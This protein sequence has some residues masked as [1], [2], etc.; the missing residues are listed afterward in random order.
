[1]RRRSTGQRFAV[2]LIC[3]L[4]LCAL[5]P[6]PARTAAELVVRL[7]GMDLPLSIS[8]LG[9]WIRGQGS[10]SSELSV[11]LNLLEEESRQGVIDLLKA[12]L[13]N[14]R[15]MARQI[16]NSWAGR[17]LLDQVSDL[18]LV[19][20]DTTGQTVQM[21]LESL[22]AK[23]PEVS[24]FD[25]LEALPAQR[26]R[27]DLDALLPVAS[28]WRLQLQRQQA[29]VKT[30][31]QLPV[32]S[33]TQSI[34]PED[35]DKVASDS[36]LQQLTLPVEHRDQPL[37]LQLWRPSPSDGRQRSH[38]LVLMPGLGGSPDHFRWLGRALSHQGWPVLVLEHPGSDALAVQALLEGRQPPPGAEVLPDRLRDLSAV[39]A[40]R[41]REVFELPGTRLVLGGHSLGA[42]T[43]LLASGAR[44]EK[45][46]A[47]R[48]GQDL[49]DLPISN[50]SR[51]LQCQ[52]EDVILPEVSPPQELA[53]VVGLNSFGSLL[54]PRQIPLSADVAVFLSGGTLDLITPPLSEQLGLLRSL[55][56][57]PAT[58][59]VLVEG[60]SHFSPVRVE[61]Q[62][63]GGQGEDVFQ[64]G[65]ELVGVQPLRVQAQLERE[66]V[67]FLIDLEAGRVSSSQKGGVEHLQV[68][69]L[70]LH[71]LDQ[72]GAAR[73][74][75]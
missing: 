59:A 68:G 64:L 71:R 50:L 9:G 55:P 39:L 8:D 38:W 10:D 51:L 14:D 34:N 43:A 66:I 24:T 46:L 56:A 47:R 26:V 44:P 19:D 52:I 35:A 61:G 75:D 69:D 58:R 62:S 32:S 7:D 25:L 13:I 27:L 74:V 22:L 57:N 1:M 73:F 72:T 49:D 31:N 41:R 65:E 17:R 42:L 11:W 21:T 48:C 63:G 15:S 30:L 54:W 5:S 20:D 18:V 53:G 37:Q 33:L 28:S 40:A 60:A 3:S 2:G 36:A 12:P 6:R 16:L 4:M 70:H 29:L 23:R 67:R 45:G